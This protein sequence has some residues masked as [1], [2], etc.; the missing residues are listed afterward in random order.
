MRLAEQERSRNALTA[1]VH[2][3]GGNRGCFG[4]VYTDAKHLME[5][6]VNWTVL[7]TQSAYP[8]SVVIA[9]NN[10]KK[11]AITEFIRDKH[12]IRV[13]DAVQ[14]LLKNQFIK[15]IDSDFILK[16]RQGIQ[17]FNGCTFLN[18]LLHV[19]TNYTALDDL[20][21]NL[22]QDHEEVLGAA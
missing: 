7:A 15:D 18:L 19:R 5:T 10:K 2:F 20:V 14:E 6:G 3:G 11:L 4:V 1:K 8:T 22:Q 17:E 9:T 13:V 21:Y 12:G 16:L